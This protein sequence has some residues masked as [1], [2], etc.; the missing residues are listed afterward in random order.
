MLD[1]RRQEDKVMLAHDVNPAGDLH[2]PLAF[3]HVVAL[4]LNQ[5]AYEV[6]TCA[7]G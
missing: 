2:Q 7:I 1:A 5:D 4:F 3:Q 6:A